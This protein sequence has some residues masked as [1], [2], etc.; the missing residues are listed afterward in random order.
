V[1][2]LVTGY[3]TDKLL[4]SE[5]R[6][7]QNKEVLMD[8]ERLG[9]ENARASEQAGADIA[10]ESQPREQFWGSQRLVAKDQLRQSEPMGTRTKQSGT[11]HTNL[12][13][14]FMSRAQVSSEAPALR[15]KQKR[16]AYR[17]LSWQ[18]FRGLINDMAF[19]L[20]SYGL[21]S[22]EC[23]GIFAGT[24]H[25]WVAADLATICNGATSVPLYPNCSLPDVQHI[26]NNSG[27]TVVFVSGEPLLKRLLEARAHLPRLR[28]IVYI[29]SLADGRSLD[30]IAN[31]EQLPFGMLVSSKELIEAGKPLAAKEPGL[32]NTRTEAIKRD[33]I[34]T[35]I[36][37]SG[38][39]GTP[40]GVPLTHGNILAVLEDLPEIIPLNSEDVYM[41]YLP[42]SHVFERVCGEFYWIYS[43]C[44]CGFAESIELLAKNL[45]EVEPT[46]MLVVPRVLDRIYAKVK[47]GIEGASGR[48]RT[49]IEW[50]VAVGA[51]VVRHQTDDQPL[52]PTLR[53]K[54]WLAEKLVL[55][56]L[57]ERIGHRL[58]RII[59]GGAPATPQT[60]EFFNAI[61]ITVLEG[62]GL[63]ETSAPTNVNRVGK[64]KI[65]TV[66]PCLPSVKMKNADDGEILLKGPTIFTGYFKDEKATRE[67]FIGGWFRTGDIGVVDG[68]GYIKITDRKKDL[69]I[70]SAGKNIA[71][72]RIENVL[73]TIPHVSQVVVFGDKKKHL[74]A[75]FTLDQQG[76]LELAQEKGWRFVSFEELRSSSHFNRYLKEEIGSRSRNLAEYEVVR[77]FAVLPEDLA[78]E[79]GELTAT[80][81]VKRNVVAQK[82]ADVINTL[83]REEAAIPG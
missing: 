74:I 37:T 6:Q 1:V 75:L 38:T 79:N 56:K 5:F 39:T 26:L 78:V 43:G 7:P 20:A 69:I 64:I 53:L 16:G 55:R 2:G 52:R 48:A 65:G 81:K 10:R 66:G 4:T 44:I 19:G 28:K 30:E 82:F 27:A 17:L 12:G 14:M 29:P 42:L 77:N 40:K 11:K 15:F 22:G 67:A 59:S 36:Y 32:I 25:L 76:V 9:P 60:I 58:G 46:I 61:G 72:Q 70:N 63:T 35:I 31:R 51:E 23:V 3:N 80:L 54:H 18:D 62:Y 71:P 49:L 8:Q 57:R 34:A 24:S 68:D 41:S 13:T 47:S 21:A 33:D 83:Y 50:A 73:K 45:G